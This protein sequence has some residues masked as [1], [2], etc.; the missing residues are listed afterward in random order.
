LYNTI[1]IAVRQYIVQSEQ[2]ASL[3]NADINF[4][5]SV[6]VLTTT[7]EKD[8]QQHNVSESSN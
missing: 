3:N 8:Q 6:H 1:G 4:K 2:G 5:C 7:L